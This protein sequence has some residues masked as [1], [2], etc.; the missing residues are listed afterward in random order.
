ML[1]YDPDGMAEIDPDVMRRATELGYKAVHVICNEPGAKVGDPT[2][3]SFI[4][5]VDFLP[6][7][8][9]RIKLEDRT[10]CEVQR[11]Y[12]GTARSADGKILTLV[13]NVSAI[14]VPKSD[15]R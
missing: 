12:F 3:V 11:V 10:V 1:N 15:Q 14:R 2:G 13:P 4:A 8:G 6:R 7:I 9:D 5:F